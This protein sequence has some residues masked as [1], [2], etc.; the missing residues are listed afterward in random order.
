VTNFQRTASWLNTCGK[1]IGDAQNISTAIGVDAEEMAEYLACLRVSQDGWG[2]VLERITQDLNDLAIAIKSGK[3][4][5]HIPQHLRVEALDAICDRQV[6]ADGV[7]F[8]AGMDKDAA[9]QEVLRSNDSKLDENG[10][11]IIAPGG[12]IMKSSRYVKPELKGFV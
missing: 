2:K 11:A 4:I 5:A 6:T 10:K 9:D 7:A 3:I 1:K 12:K 8:L